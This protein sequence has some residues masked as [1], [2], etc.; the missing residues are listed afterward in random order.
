LDILKNS[1]REV[2]QNVQHKRKEDK[3]NVEQLQDDSI[4][5]LYSRRLEDVLNEPY[6]GSSEGMYEYMKNAIRKIAHEASSIKIK[7]NYRTNWMTT[8]VLGSINL[9]KR[10]V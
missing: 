10:I 5:N 2:N 6:E 8:E 4:W 7:K 1:S 3:F 9:K